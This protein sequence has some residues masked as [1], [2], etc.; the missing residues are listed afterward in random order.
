MIK[1]RFNGNRLESSKINVQQIN[2]NSNT[3]QKLNL[4]NNIN[5]YVHIFYSATVSR[6]ILRGSLNN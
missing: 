3:S 2:N 5:T 4:N 6:T 1:Q